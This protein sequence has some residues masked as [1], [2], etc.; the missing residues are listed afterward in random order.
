M[1]DFNFIS[2]AYDSLDY[3]TLVGMTNEIIDLYGYPCVYRKFV[4]PESVNHPLYR[5]RLT[6]TNN[7]EQFY[8]EKETKVLLENKHFVPQLMAQGY[9]LNVETPLNAFMKL[10]DE[11]GVED[12]VTL[13]YK[14]EARRYTFQ[15]NSATNWKNLC[16]NVVLS[17]YVQDDMSKVEEE[18]PTLPTGRKKRRRI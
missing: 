17:V 6:S 14:H 16:T 5:D 2:S 12:L 9:A 18:Q 11:V 13:L 4:G 10:E 7:V 15:V 1:S 8:V 3:D